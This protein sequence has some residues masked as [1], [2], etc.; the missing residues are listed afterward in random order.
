ML[1]GELNY[2]HLFYEDV[3]DS[4]TMTS[5]PKKLY[6]PLTDQ[7]MFG[8]F[9]LLITVILM[10]LLVGLAVSDIQVDSHFVLALFP[11]D[12]VLELLYFI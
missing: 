7:I 2:D 8:V 3:H 6:Y 9:V 5:V 1:V 10:N 11:F 12:S 4:Q